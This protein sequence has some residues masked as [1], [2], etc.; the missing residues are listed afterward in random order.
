MAFLPFFFLHQSKSMNLAQIVQ[1]G[2]QLP[3]SVDFYLAPPGESPDTDGVADMA[4]DR[5]D[6]PQAHAVDVAAQC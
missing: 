6:D 1:H 3:L 2:H 5:L 4:E